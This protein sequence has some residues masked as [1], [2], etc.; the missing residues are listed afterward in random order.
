M[1]SSISEPGQDILSF[2]KL[3]MGTFSKDAKCYSI[4][5]AML[6]CAA[7]ALML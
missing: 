5:I 2:V 1:P 3:A 4:L 6:V 7:L